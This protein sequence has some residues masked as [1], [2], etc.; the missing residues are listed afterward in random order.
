MIH[1]KQQHQVKQDGKNES[2]YLLDGKW[3]RIANHMLVDLKFFIS[4]VE[5]NYF[6]HNNIH[7]M[8]ISLCVVLVVLVDSL[9]FEELVK[10]A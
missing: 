2:S 10:S 1:E 3:V 9:D 7:V 6:H 4:W 5:K 8:R